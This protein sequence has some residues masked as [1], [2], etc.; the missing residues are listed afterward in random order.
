MTISNYLLNAVTT[1]TVGDAIKN[2]GGAKV[3]QI[4]GVTASGGSVTL[5]GRLSDDLNWTVLTYGGNPAIFTEDKI[6]KLDFWA[7]SLQLRATLAGTSGT[8]SVS[9]VLFG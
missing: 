7:P 1:D 2:A 6:L 3:I 8:F 5:E 4:S 9:V